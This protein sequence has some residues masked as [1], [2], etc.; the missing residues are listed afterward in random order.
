MR[1]ASTATA[2]GVMSTRFVP[3]SRA[4]ARW[5]RSNSIVA[6]AIDATRP[7]DGVG[8]G[9]MTVPGAFVGTPAYMAPEQAAGV[10]VDHR[11][12]LYAWGVVAY[13]M[14]AGEHP[15]ARRTNRQRFVAAQMGLL[16]EPLEKRRSDVPSGVSEL[17]MQCLAADAAARPHDASALITVLGASSGATRGRRG[18]LL[19]EGWRR[20]GQRV[21]TRSGRLAI[22]TAAAAGAVLTVWAARHAELSSLWVTASKRSG[23]EAAAPASL[24]TMAYAVMVRDTIPSEMESDIA[25]LFQDGLARWR[26]V[27]VE[28]EGRVSAVLAR[29]TKG[30]DHGRQSAA[31]TL[32]VG[33]Y[34][35]V[36]ASGDGDSLA[37]SSTLFDTQTGKAISEA[38]VR[39]VRDRRRVRIAMEGLAD[40]LLFRQLP[41]NDRVD[42]PAGTQSWRA[43]QMYLRGHLALA[44]GRL[45]QAETLFFGATQQDPNYAHA[46]V[47]LANVRSWIGAADRPW[48][49]L[50]PQAAA[51][52]S[53]LGFRDSLV[54]AALDAL[55]AGRPDRACAT[56]RHLTSI[57]TSDFAAW[58][59]LGNCLRRDDLVV[60]SAAP[61]KEWVFRSSYQEEASAYE[62]AFKLRPAFLRAFRDGPL[63]QLQWLLFTSRVRLRFGRASP[64]SAL[65]FN[66]YPIVDGDTIAFV[67]LP[68]QDLSSPDAVDEATHHERLRFREIVRMW[69]AEYPN[70]PEAAEAVGVASE[71]LGDDAAIEAFLRARALAAGTPDELRIAAR[72]VLVRVKLSLPSGLNELR[73]AR[74]LADS[75]IRAN[76]PTTHR[77]LSLLASLAA[78]TGRA[79]L[80]AAYAGSTGGD[81][82]YPAF[83]RN[84][85][86]LL[87]FASLGGPSDSL[88]A[89]EQ[90]VANAITSL[91]VSDR[92]A[93]SRN[94]LS[95]AGALAFPDYRL[96]SVARASETGLRMGNLVTASW[97]GDTLVVRHRIAEFTAAQ[98]S[99]RPVD[100]MTDGLLPEA[101]ALVRLGDD[102]AA[103]QFLDPTLNGL[104]YSAAQDLA[105]VWRSGSLVRV[106]ALRAEIAHRR[107]DLASA[108]AWARPVVE[109]WSGADA[110]LQ[111]TVERMRQLSR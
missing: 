71:M 20:I 11:A 50:V 85:A 61:T 3:A 35:L 67:V 60:Q 30:D 93:A 86:A 17:V 84:G 90:L 34:V 53:K 96:A 68:V 95:R 12:D 103:E 79:G 111:P 29:S 101:A 40:S 51:Q 59:S 32:G 28:D 64:P 82:T 31:E 33:R 18:G 65:R 104:R 26:D 7:P 97:A 72:E 10:R 5:R 8:G 70:D 14:I 69:S 74:T 15:F 81:P 76:P 24:D 36:G 4:V 48:S 62:H 87:T 78:L 98:R 1:S 73:V 56:L 9:T 19:R 105:F 89:L 44:D 58:Y 46:L 27:R 42:R 108:R 83:G 23:R 110:F 66:G 2:S 22:G 39:T 99:V 6:K 94:Y 55:A 106:M 75:L 41:A 25:G 45:E 77:E 37:I 102:R 54:L 100:I 88:R 49:Q 38:A 109:L 47:W 107:G 92:E 80:A 52:R 57:A 13:E 16:P 43:R 63:P 91:P 21:R